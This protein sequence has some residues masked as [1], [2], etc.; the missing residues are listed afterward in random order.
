[1]ITAS[2]ARFEPSS[3]VMRASRMLRLALGSTGNGIG[4]ARSSPALTSAP[5][6]AESV[7]LAI[8][9]PGWISRKKKKAP[10]GIRLKSTRPSHGRFWSRQPPR[11]ARQ[12][13]FYW[14]GF[15]Y[16]HPRK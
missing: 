5:S 1:M 3:A 15:A 10:L 13:K 11:E 8:S 16:L 12:N 2:G 4:S 9:E 7:H 6:A 14:R